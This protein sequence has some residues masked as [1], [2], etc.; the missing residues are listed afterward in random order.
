MNAPLDRGALVL[1]FL[2]SAC[3]DASAPLPATARIEFAEVGERAGLTLVQSS[4]DARRW[5]IPESNGTGAAWLDYDGDGDLDLFV[6]NGQHVRYLDHG[7]RLE[8]VRDARSALYRNDGNLRFTD[9]SA[10]TGCERSDWVQAIATADVDNDGDTDLYLGCIGADVLLRND[11]GRFVDA[12][13]ESGLRNE[14][15]AAGAAFADIDNDGW[16]DLY[17]ANYCLFDFA[18]PPNKGVRNV[19]KGLEV[20]WGPEE[21]NKQGFNPGA[22]DVLFKGLGGG[23]FREATAE[24]GLVLPRALCSYAAVFSDIDGDLD[25]D[26]LVGNDMQPSNLFVNDGRG[27]FTEEGAARGFALGADG[28]A[29]SAMGLVPED[30]DGDGDF[31]VLRTNFDFEPNSLHVNDGTGHFTDRARP[32]GLAAG[33]VDKLGWGAGFFDAELDGD[34]DLLIA[35]GHVYPQAKEIG[36]SGWKMETQLYEAVTGSSGA[37]V[38]LDATVR[39][40]GGLEGLH[41]ARGLALGDP[42]EDGDIDALV[43][44]LDERPRL[45]ENR[46]ARGGRWLAVQLEGSR[47]NRDGIGAVVAVRSGGRTWTREARRTSGLYSSHDPRLH[48][49]LGPVARID[50]VEV[51]WPSGARSEVASPS[52]DSILV[53]SEEPS[54]R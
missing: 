43:T 18:N 37:V 36:M 39:I 34:L 41:S 53:V 28:R 13:A 42:D 2:F 52:L 19:I 20:A 16:L 38:W 33:S 10:A 46:S 51:R 54:S 49:G 8:I 45:L 11:G 23:K 5:Y 35:N 40:G 25:Q 50:S 12:T 9:V 21:E 27:H 6:G 15:W 22:P 48:F 7:A 31:D 14:L 26:L 4:G 29:T 32:L 44:D 3:G 1:A 24:S 47:S 30:V 17:V